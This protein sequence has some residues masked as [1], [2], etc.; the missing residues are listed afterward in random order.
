MV[1]GGCNGR[2]RAD[3]ACIKTAGHVGAEVD[4]GHLHPAGP[5]RRANIASSHSQL[6]A[7]FSAGG[8]VDG[9]PVPDLDR[10]RDGHVETLEDIMVVDNCDGD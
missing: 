8:E 3:I 7:Q 4:V 9:G 10:R 6:D 5:L 2:V 1:L